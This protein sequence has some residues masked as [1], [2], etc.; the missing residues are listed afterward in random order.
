M[1]DGLLDLFDRDRARSS[2]SPKSFKRGLRGMIDRL[3][4]GHDR[5]DDDRG[6]SARRH[7]GNDGGET[8]H[9][10]RGPRRRHDR[11]DWD[12]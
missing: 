2:T 12:D 1:F 8:D 10:D 11:F 5:D 6:L 7:D 3:A 4:D 9:I